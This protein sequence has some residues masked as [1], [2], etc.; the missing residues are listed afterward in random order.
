M[1]GLKRRFSNRIQKAHKGQGL[2]E[3]ALIMPIFLMLIMGIVELGR[4]M[5]TYTGVASASREAARYGAAVGTN[6]SGVE[7]YRD[8]DGIRDQARRVAAL[9]PIED[10]DIVIEYDNPVT[11]Y[12]VNACPPVVLE[13][14]D[15]I[16]VTVT[17]TFEPIVPLINIPPLPLR[18]TT[19]RTVLRDIYVK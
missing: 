11:G 18:S 4:L 15:R 2:V 16:V 10:S 6:A 14:G 9:A 5:I 13:L 8:C 19:A 1:S 7:H 12:H 3:F 17:I